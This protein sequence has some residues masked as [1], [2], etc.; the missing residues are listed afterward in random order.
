MKLSETAKAFKE[1][2]EIS[3]LD[4][5]GLRIG[6]AQNEEAATGMTVLISE[7]GMR[8]GL[9]VRGGGPASRDSQML[10]PLM[11]MQKIHGIV[12]SGGSAFGLGA[13]DGVM[14]YLEEHDIGFDTG[15]AKVPLVVQSDIFD[16]SVGS[17]KVRPDREMGYEAAKAAF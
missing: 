16:L 5:E 6:Q 8:A 3:V 7:T 1:L 13:A 15:V 12:L 9:D 2:K 4:I 14:K 11:A 10:N 17:A